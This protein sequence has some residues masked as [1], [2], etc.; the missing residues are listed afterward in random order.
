[1][2]NVAIHYSASIVDGAGSRKV[3]EV[4]VSEASLSSEPA[5]INS[6]LAD[7]DAII[8][9]VIVASQIRITPALPTTLGTTGRTGFTTSQVGRLGGFRFNVNGTQ[10]HWSQEI[11]AFA[12]AY[13]LSGKTPNVTATAVAAYLSLM[14]SGVPTT[15]TGFTE[16]L[17][18]AVLTGLNEAFGGDRKVHGYRKASTAV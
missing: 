2:P 16:P 7:L 17:G 8:D 3:T 6:W 12:Q 18:L 14:T 4:Y 11:P 10:K 5:G 1:M 13:L 9:G 15:N